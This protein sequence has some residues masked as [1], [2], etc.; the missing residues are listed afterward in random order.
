[1][2]EC[3]DLCVLHQASGTLRRWRKS[4]LSKRWKGPIGCPISIGSKSIALSG[5]NAVPKPFTELLTNE[6]SGS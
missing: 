2:A 3:H 6:R 4:G 1:M 5:S